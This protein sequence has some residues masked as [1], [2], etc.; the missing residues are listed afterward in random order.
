MKKTCFTLFSFLVSVLVVHGQ[1]LSQEEY[2]SKYKNLA[3]SEMY[4]S[5]V[6]AS[7]TLAQGILETESG[8]SPL[9]LRS[10]NHFGIKCKSNWNGPSVSHDDD[11]RDECF[12]AYGSAEESYRDHSDFLK[13]SSRYAFLF[14]YESTNY[15]DWAFGLK[16]AGY[17]T[18]PRYPEMLI[19]FIETNNLQ[20]Y[21]T[22]NFLLA[23]NVDPE[24]NYDVFHTAIQEKHPGNNQ[25]TNTYIAFSNHVVNGSKAIFVPEGTSLLAI[26]TRQKIHL[27]K[28]LELNDLKKDGLLE[29]GQFIF[30]EKKASQGENEFYITEAGETIYDVAQKNGVLLESILLF[31]KLGENDRL[32]PGKKLYLKQPS[33]AS[34]KRASF[35]TEKIHNLAEEKEMYTHKVE[36]KEGLYSISKRY[37]ISVDQIKYWNNLPDDL[38]KIGQELIIS[39]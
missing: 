15:K 19:R 4:R 18:N 12:R 5:G 31:N 13:N 33:S 37:G 35:N 2:I 17:A 32:Q 10:N 3:I 16:Q 23:N 30:L 8:N 20:Q 11:E 6:P 21:D 26:A 14:N 7:I 28:L 9:V 38:L 34:V 29:R 36:P 1:K 39:K 24:P 25:Q 22:A 27:S